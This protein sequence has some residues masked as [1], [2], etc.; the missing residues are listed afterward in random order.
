VL[1]LK[2]D[3]LKVVCAEFSTLSLAVFVMS[4]IE[5]HLQA[6]PHLELKTQP[7]FHP[8]C[9]SLPMTSGFKLAFDQGTLNEKGG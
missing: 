3:S 2:G 6:R 7:R 1:K 8:V 9:L 4:V 5:W